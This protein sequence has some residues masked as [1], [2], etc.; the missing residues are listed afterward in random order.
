MQNLSRRNFFKLG[1]GAL[2][3]AAF[4]DLT[5]I[6]HKAFAQ[7]TNISNFKYVAVSLDKLP[8]AVKAVQNSELVKNAYK[9]IVDSV[10][11]IENKNLQNKTLDFIKDTRPT[12]MQLYTSSTAVT[13]VYN[14]LA[15]KGFIDTT[16]IS[17]EQLFPVVKNLKKN[18]QEFISAPGSGYASHHAYPGGLSTHVAANISISEGIVNTYKLIFGYTVNNDIVLSAQAL[19]DLAKPWVFQWNNDGTCL[20]EYTIAGTGAHHILGLVEAIYRNMPAEEII[21]QACAHNHPG[22]DKDE[23]DVVN[24]LK[25][26]AIIAQ[27][28]PIQYGLLDK[29]GDKLPIPQ[30]QEGYIVHLGDHDWVLSGIAAKNIVLYLK[31]IAKT[32]YNF[33]DKDLNGQLFNNFRNYLGSQVSFMY[34]HNLMAQNGLEDVRNLVHQIILK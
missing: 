5:G 2:A 33:S 28:N 34:L 13:A 4:F 14:E 11:K 9:Y 19:H 1:A 22:S 24:W 27:K 21:A 16:I 8:E 26:A 31:E 18:P 23:N 10:Q 32:D 15:N 7:G 29:S 30:H 25:S 12:F 17:P 3:G 20:K 6:S